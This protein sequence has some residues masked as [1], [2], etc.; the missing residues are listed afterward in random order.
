MPSH[1]KR[2]NRLALEKS[3]YLLQHAENPVD[4]YP[5]GVEA[6]QKAKEED[7]PIFLS[8]GYAS[9]H[10][11][12][13]MEQESFNNPEVAELMNQKFVNIKV[14]REELPEVDN[15]YM[16][17]AQGLMPGTPGWPLN[18]ILTP[19]LKP[20]FAATYLPPFDRGDMMGLAQ[21]LHKI[22]SIWNSSEKEK[23]LLQAESLTETFK[24]GIKPKGSQMPTA[25]KVDDGSELLFQL[26]DPMWGGLS[27]SPKFPIGYQSIFLIRHTAL[28]Q[29]ARGIFMAEK[30]LDMMQRGGIY[31]HIGGGFS[32]YSIDKEW[33][34][35]HFE[36]MLYDNALLVDAHL[37][38]YQATEK[39]LFKKIADECLKYIDRVLTSPEGAFYTSEGADANGEEGGFYTWDKEEILQALGKTKGEL[40]ADYFGMSDPGNYRG[41]NLMH[42][43]LREEEFS[44]MK[45]LDPELVEETVELAKNT[46]LEIREKRP[47]P[48]IDDKILVSLNGLMIH[49]LSK[50]ARVLGNETY[51]KRAIKAAEFIKTHMFQGDFLFR[52]FRDQ[53]VR[54][55]GSLDDYAFMIRGLIELFLADGEGEWLEFALDLNRILENRFKSNEGAYFFAEA[56]SQH[57]LLRKCLFSDGAEPSGNAVQCE[58]L[59]KLST[60]TFEDRYL[61]QA[62]DIFRGV[63][64]FVDNYPPG[65]IYHLMNLELYNAVSGAKVVIIALN[66]KSEGL[67]QIKSWFQK[68][69]NPLVQ[70]IYK[71]EEDKALIKALPHLETYV[72]KDNRTT[73]YLCQDKACQAPLTK[74]SDMEEAILKL[75]QKV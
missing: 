75:G 50:A 30:T 32:R 25:A 34:V 5:W 29:D 72:P 55:E 61:A 3:P 38:L 66:S 52:R 69:Y 73:F 14:D 74:M 4:W 59:L 40:V 37:E 44:D 7:R 9:C 68:I 58:N 13:V 67:Y 43:L 45:G 41:T 16:E 53:E 42:L 71:R 63:K 28:S 6:F 23:V 39:P 47:R 10:W 12:H 56:G 48:K 26:S 57:L 49:A 46:L 20:F 2:K 51:L 19:E 60:L 33:R 21:V 31:D 24:Q 11:C 70:V 22:S 1:P 64:E 17:F 36:K 35:P 15:L 62:E 27:G 8:I 18:V 54:Y 65:Y